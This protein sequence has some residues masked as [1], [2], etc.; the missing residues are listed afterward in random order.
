MRIL[1][2]EDYT[3]LRE[4][5]TEHL[6]DT[7]FAVDATPDGNEGLKFATSHKYDAIVL[8]DVAL[9]STGIPAGSSQT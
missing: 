6:K 4:S 2:I 8:D 1:L 7:G 9:I 3:P 5:I